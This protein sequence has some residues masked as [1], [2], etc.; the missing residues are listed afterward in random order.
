[1]KFNSVDVANE[2]E[3][4]IEGDDYVFE[5][6]QWLRPAQIQSFWSRLTKTRRQSTL[7]KVTT[8]EQESSDDNSED[9]DDTDGRF[10]QVADEAK[11]HLAQSTTRSQSRVA[12]QTVGNNVSQSLPTRGRQTLRSMDDLAPEQKK[13]RHANS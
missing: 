2:M 10:E 7:I 4:L 3:V 8:D 9:E 12:L 11:A 13:T 6:H 1:M 5:P